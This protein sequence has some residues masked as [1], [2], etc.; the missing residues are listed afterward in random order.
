MP[1]A[2]RCPT[3]SEERYADSQY[4]D[5]KDRQLTGGL[6]ICYYCKKKFFV[7]DGGYQLHDKTWKCRDCEEDQVM[8]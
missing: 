5:W 8:W 7:S 3:E 1:S 2:G 4:D 6:L